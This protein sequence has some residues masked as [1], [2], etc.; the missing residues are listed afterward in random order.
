MIDILTLWELDDCDDFVTL[1]DIELDDS[2]LRL[3]L[4]IEILWE[5]EDWDDLVSLLL[6]DFVCDPLALEDDFVSD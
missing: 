2:E 1:A 5:L 4:V 6:L 3:L